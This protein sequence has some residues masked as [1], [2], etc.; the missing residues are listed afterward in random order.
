MKVLG[1]ILM[2][3]LVFVSCEDDYTDIYSEYITN[4]SIETDFMFY[5]IE[6]YEI[7]NEVDTAELRLRFNSTLMFPV[8]NNPISTSSFIENNELIIRFDSIPEIGGITTP[9]PAS[10]E[11]EL[12]ENIDRLV[13]INGSIVDLYHV[14]VTKEYV[15]VKPIGKNYTQLQYSKIFRYPE[16]T[17]VYKCKI[18]TS[19]I[20]V[21]SDFLKILTANLSIVEFEFE[22]EGKIPY[23]EAWVEGNRRCLTKYYKYE[24]ELE[25]EFEKAGILLEDFTERYIEPNTGTLI[26]LISWIHIPTIPCQ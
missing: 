2:L 19:Q 1:S 23:P 24:S 12:P 17:F 18:D 15:D 7:Y 13:L 3:M 11:I 14:D 8:G 5:P 9:G 4:N 26:S 16:N 20:E 25:F 21:Y 10:T 22:G 6:T